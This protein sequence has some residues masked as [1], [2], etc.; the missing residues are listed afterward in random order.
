MSFQMVYKEVEMLP[1]TVCA[2][3]VV[4]TLQIWKLRQLIYPGQ[5]YRR[6]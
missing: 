6:P 4:V 1:M 3:F 2:A 5:V